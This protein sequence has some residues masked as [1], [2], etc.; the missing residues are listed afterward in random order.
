MHEALKSWAGDAAGAGTDSSLPPGPAAVEDRRR[1]DRVPLEGA[2]LFLFTQ[3]DQRF[4]LRV[5]DFACTGLSG[6][7]D[8]PLTEGQSLI[9]QLEEM[10][11][12]GAEVVWTNGGLAGL[13]LIDPVPPARFK[14]LCE[15]HEAGAAWSP[16]MRAGSDL[17]CWWTD[18]EEQQGGRRARLDS[19]GHDHPLPR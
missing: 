12:P 10:L 7:T 9:V 11:M 19:G 16:A 14:R 15:R 8:A 13:R 17:H 1:A 6:I 18:V 2:E 4:R 5:R 3:G